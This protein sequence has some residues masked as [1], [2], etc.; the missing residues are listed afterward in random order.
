MDLGLQLTSQRND[1]HNPLNSHHPSE[2]VT[3]S[4]GSVPLTIFQGSAPGRRLGAAG[5]ACRARHWREKKRAYVFLK[6]AAQR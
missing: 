4:G 3:S 2:L 5:T 6:T 1:L